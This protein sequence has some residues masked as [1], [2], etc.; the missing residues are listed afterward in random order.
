MKQSAGILLFRERE[1]AL[2]VF[3]VHYGGP[4]WAKKDDGSWSV[5]KGEFSGEEKPLDAALRE[6]REETGMELKPSHIIPLKSVKQKGGKVIHCWAIE[7]D[8]DPVKMVSNEFEMEWPP[9]SGKKKSFPEIDRGE[10]FDVE[11][12]KRKINEVQ[13]QFIDELR[14]YL[15]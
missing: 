7:G 9:K 4:F 5:P 10:W 15:Q 13:I 3:L 14:S 6:F 2:Q 1:N 8:I 11:T 12:A